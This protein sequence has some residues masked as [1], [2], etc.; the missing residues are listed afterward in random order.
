ME[1]FILVAKVLSCS[2]PSTRCSQQINKVYCNKLYS[3]DMLFYYLFSVTISL[4]KLRV[5]ALPRGL[6]RYA[7]SWSTFSLFA[8]HTNTHACT[9]PS[10]P[11]LWA[12]EPW[13]QLVQTV[14]SNWAMSLYTQGNHPLLMKKWTLLQTS[15]PWAVKKKEK[16]KNIFWKANAAW[17]ESHTSPCWRK[18]L[19]VTVEQIPFIPLSMLR[20]MSLLWLILPWPLSR[21]IFLWSM[22][23]DMAF[24]SDFSLDEQG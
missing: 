19:A 10:L 5:K 17:D 13:L 3:A 15:W 21:A 1:T 4:I 7:Q 23:Q 8:T 9:K 11:Y 20:T 12:E 24:H 6:L 14:L 22:T 2:W 16:K 18:T